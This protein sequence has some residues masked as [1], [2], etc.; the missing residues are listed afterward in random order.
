MNEQVW[1]MSTLYRRTWVAGHM[2]RAL[3]VVCLSLLLVPVDAVA[4]ESEPDEAEASGE[5][6]PTWDDEEEVD[7]AGGDF[8]PSW[9]DEEE[10]DEAGGDFAPS[11][12]DEEEVDEAGGEFAPSWGDEEEVDEA[13]GDFAPSWGDD[14]EV[15]E[16]GGDFAPS[17]EDEEEVDEAGGDFAPTLE[18]E[19]QAPAESDEQWLTDDDEVEEDGDWENYWE[20][21]EPEE[22]VE[23]V[24]I[25]TEM[26]EGAGGVRGVVVDDEF[27]DPLYGTTVTI[28]ETDLEL[29]TGSTGEF[30]FEL[31]PG[32]YVMRLRNLSYKPEA[33]EVLVE[34]SAVTDLGLIRLVTDEERTMTIVV[35]GR[36]D[37][38]TVATQM[39]ERREETSMTN[40]I[41]AEEI[42]RSADGSASSAVGR[43][44]GVTIV[45]GQFV[46]VRGLGGRY[47]RV[48]FNGITVPNTDPDFPSASLDLFPSGLIA[49]LTLLKTAS[50]DRPGDYA[51]GM[52]DIAS[53]AYPED[54][55]L[56]FG[57]SV[58]GDTMTTFATGPRDERGGLDWLGLDDGG[59][60]LPEVVPADRRVELSDDLTQEDL[61]RIGE[62][63]RN[64]WLPA[65][66]TLMPNLGLSAQVGDEVEVGNDRLGYLASLRYS[67]KVQR[68]FPGRIRLASLTPE[69]TT[70]SLEDLTAERTRHSVLWGALGTLTWSPSGTHDLTAVTTYTQSG[71]STTEIVAGDSQEEALPIR[72]TQL[73]YI[74]RGLFL[75][76]LAGSHRALPLDSDL[77]W[78]AGV[79]RAQRDEPDTRF[80]TQTGEELVWRPNPGSGER[81]F[82]D[83]AQTD[84]FGGVDW[85]FRPTLD[86]RFKV[87]GLVQQSDRQFDSRRFRYATNS[88]RV[89][90]LRAD[91][92]FTSETIGG[93][94]E[95]VRI[96]EVTQATDSYTSVQRNYGGYGMVDWQMWSWLRFIAGARYE[97]FVQEID[98]ESPFAGSAATGQSADRTDNDVIP[99][100]SLVF[101]LT[102]EMFIRTGYALTVARPQ[103]REIAPF[104]YQDYVRRRTITGNPDLLQTTVH[105]ADVRWEWFPTTTE[106]LA[107]TVFFKQFDNPIES[108]IVDQ[109]GNITYANVDEATNLG[110][111]LEGRYSF[112]N[113]S[114]RLEG[115]TFGANLALIRSRIELPECDP[116]RSEDGEC[117]EP[118][119]TSKSRALAGQSPWVVN[120]VVG[121]EP[122]NT[123]IGA[124]LFYNVLGPRI[125]GVGGVGLPDI[126]EYS[127]H[128]L[129]LTFQWGF[130]EHWNT[131]AAL[132]N[133]LMQGSRQ[134]QGEIDVVETPGA[135]G[136]SL[137]LGWEL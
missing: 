57:V 59:R 76:Q 134:E 55:S 85:L 75:G 15:D 23:D 10:V 91:Q 130:A 8:A 112:G 63:F 9:G 71:I 54:F 114:D 67:N 44:V 36:A 39:M 11:W 101:G 19:E 61:E 123:E 129:D 38:N 137:G 18:Q 118:T 13:G 12:G 53:R 56:E 89:R 25:P 93:G 110:V 14:E 26:E 17:W 72:R 98:A 113:L 66:R 24:L 82:A 94:P 92:L 127:P 106:L 60:A 32:T 78:R 69:G 74:E 73:Q 22:V 133:L 128:R 37:Q 30:F 80:L 102:E 122:P 81:F 64:A 33:F 116:I 1:S 35:E 28:E 7:E 50:A 115:L 34:P 88:F 95:G 120:A 31:E 119:Y 83:M 47:T 132:T 111:E 62:S 27:G 99:S 68:E 77:E 124:F 86:F 21:L 41:S 46:F 125:E 84:Y 49:N 6:A 103:A 51:G 136:F 52:V 70:T 45:D 96:S 108:L 79:S 104:V 109:R 117:A 135:L 16:A 121:Y 90:Q 2:L 48:M 87:G 105:N 42:S 3:V 97:S 126:L 107:A 29:T 131:S 65:E 4:Q 43:I 20:E 5:F 58:S 40:A 100:G